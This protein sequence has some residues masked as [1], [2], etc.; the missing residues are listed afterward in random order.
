[1]LSD[2]Q[3]IANYLKGDE[4]S[5]E[6]LV[7]QYLKPIYSFVY[8]YVGEAG[9]AEDVT[10]EVFARLWQNIKKF[11]PQKSFKTWIFSIAKNAAIDFLRKKKAVPLSDFEDEKGENFLAETLA[12]ST[13]LPDELFDQQDLAQKLTVA[14]NKLSPKYRLA[15]LLRYNDHFT[16]QEMAECLGEPL[17]TIKSRYRRALIILRKLLEMSS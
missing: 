15:L 6:I 13:P 5:L 7:K 8:H 17:D 12:D 16:F 3:L 14:I 1:M 2:E 10:Q 4:K 11:N 9:E